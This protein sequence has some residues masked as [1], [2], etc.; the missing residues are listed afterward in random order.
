[1]QDPFASST[2]KQRTDW[3][4]NR[5]IEIFSP[6]YS[7]IDPWKALE[8]EAVFRALERLCHVSGR[9]HGSKQFSRKTTPD[10]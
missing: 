8:H 4:K 1:M 7:T 2:F 5:K 3:R 6:L 10:D 9:R